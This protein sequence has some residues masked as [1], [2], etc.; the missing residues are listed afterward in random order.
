VKERLKKL[1]ALGS[2]L[3]LIVLGGCLVRRLLRREKPEVT[4]KPLLV[5]GPKEPGYEDRRDTEHVEEQLAVSGAGSSSLL[6]PALLVLGIALAVAGQVAFTKYRLNIGLILYGLSLPLSIYAL[7][8]TSCAEVGDQEPHHRQRR[9]RASVLLITL[10]VACEIMILWLDKRDTLSEASAFPLYFLCVALFAG[11]FLV[12]DGNPFKKLSGNP[13]E[14]VLLALILL[15]AFGLR[16]Y[17]VD[18]MPPGFW[19]DE[20]NDGMEAL[21]VLS[22]EFPSPFRVDWGGNPAMKAFYN[23]LAVKLLGQNKMAIRGVAVAFGTLSVLFTYLLARQ[24]FSARLAFL[25]SFLLTISRWHIHRSRFDSVVIGSAFFQVLAFYFL[26]RGFRSRRLSDFAWSGLA[27]GLGLNS[28]HGAR[29][30]PI[31]VVTLA[32]HQVLLRRGDFVRQHYRTFAVLVLGAA[33][34]FAPLGLYYSGNVNALVGRARDV[35]IFNNQQHFKS[36]YG[37]DYSNLEMLGL[38]VKN[39]LLMFNFQGDGNGINNWRRLPMLD[40]VTS[41]LLVLGVGYSLVRWKDP[42]HF[43]LL[44]WLVLTLV[45]GSVLTIG[46]PHSARTTGVIAVLCIEAAIFLDAAW[47]ALRRALPKPGGYFLGAVIAATLAVSGYVNLDLYF[48]KY[49]Q[50]RGIWHMFAGTVSQMADYIQS[51]G[52][53]IHVHFL[54]TEGINS[55]NKGIQFLSG[56]FDAQDFW[57]LSTL[58]P[59][60]EEPQGEIVYI[61]PDSAA[62]PLVQHFYP[63]GTLKQF[64]DPFGSPTFVSYEVS[65]DEV[66]S[67]QGLTGRY[68]AGDAWEGEAILV[69]RDGPIAFDWDRDSPVNGPFSVLWEG[70]LYIPQSGRSDFF[71]DVSGNVR[72]FIDRTSVLATENVDGLVTAAV[73]LA[74]GLHAVTLRYARSDEAGGW[75][76]WGWA[77]PGVPGGLVPARFLYTALTNH[78]LLGRYYA[79]SEWSGQPSFQQVDP[80]LC[81]MWRRNIDPLPSPFSVEWEGYLHVEQSGSYT[82]A[83]LSSNGSWLY[84][85]DQLVVD[86]GGQHS[87]QDRQGVVAL[88]AGQHRI[89]LRYVHTEAWRVMEVY[90]TP[91]DGR[92]EILPTDHL[93][94]SAQG[95]VQIIASEPVTASMRG[96]LPLGDTLSYVTGWGALGRGR[97]QFNRPQDVAVSPGGDVYVVDTGNYRVQRFDA[98]GRFLDAWGSRGEGPGQFL[99]PWAMGIDSQGNVYVLDASTGRV[100]KFTAEGQFLGTF[101]ENSGFYSPRGLAIDRDGNLYVADTGGNRVVKLSPQGEM[102]AWFGAGVPVAAGGL[103]QPD[104]VAIDDEGNVLVSDKLNLRLQRFDP[105]G[106]PVG[107]WPLTWANSDRGPRIAFGPQGQVLLLDPQGARIWVYDQAGRLLTHWGE[108][109]DDLGQLEYPTGIAVDREGYVY[110]VDAGAHRVHK[111]RLPES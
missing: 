30:A 38:Q 74:R 73:D 96:L 68:Y 82:F 16:A 6:R 93:L 97:G 18:I 107:E 92:Q 65:V 36:M 34:L 105:S 89:K 32:A 76:R 72:L 62:V 84:V 3:F 100:Q 83:T 70:T 55:S 10:A 75:I 29:I 35:W 77:T 63:N 58:V 31:I 28:Y 19:T 64:Q 20:G 90:W 44:S 67:R 104:D 98:A 1:V 66:I 51:L 11:A 49:M 109:G 102:L 59:A 13:R 78:G 79:N 2:S 7:A 27:L 53:G 23:A 52:P 12:L 39:T 56:G 25:A 108:P 33:L 60:H 37:R 101:G 99:E 4:D 94:P 5:P 21:Q 91:P 111:F 40:F 57:N 85:D 81:F 71:L 80:Y 8:A 14:I 26:Y 46:A 61:L 48:N 95:L 15:L 45:T 69:R 43:F 22:G 103:N 9:E 86:N 110:V 24:L 54:S 47:E 50:D 42:R 41:L 106:R 87:T 17:R 88:E